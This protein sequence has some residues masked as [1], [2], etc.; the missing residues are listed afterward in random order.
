MYKIQSTA[1]TISAVKYY[2][3]YSAVVVVL[4]AGADT[5]RYGRWCVQGVAEEIPG[6]FQ[7]YT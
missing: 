3:H 7:Y 2:I 5:T 1:C 4:L 6:M